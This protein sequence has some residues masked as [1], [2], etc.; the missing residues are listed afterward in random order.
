MNTPRTHIWP[1]VLA[2]CSQLL[3]AC[4]SE[5]GAPHVR[6][7]YDPI[8]YGTLVVGDAGGVE[9]ISARTAT[10]GSWRCSSVIL[11]SSWLLTAEHCVLDSPT[12]TTPQTV[13]VVYG[14]D[15]YNRSREADRVAVLSTQDI[16][17]VHFPDGVL[18]SLSN[19]MYGGSD[20]SLVGQT[21]RCYGYGWSDPVEYLGGDLRTAD[22]TV[23]ETGYYTCGLF[24]T[25]YC[26]PSHG[27]WLTRNSLGQI[28]A[29]GDSG[30]PCFIDYGATRYITGITH[31]ASSDG[32]GA[33]QVGAEDF[34]DWA[35]TT[36]GCSGPPG[37]QASCV[38][39]A[40]EWNCPTGTSYCSGQCMSTATATRT[41]PGIPFTAIKYLLE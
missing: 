11:N 20:Q 26:Y 19:G 37:S 32:T 16:A 15:S 23:T 1:L 4:G 17:L 27:Y 14:D 5:Q 40:C 22:L 13:I 2:A 30:G 24:S 10:H 39:G 38:N 28:M 33:S 9:E 21:L 3:L 35:C 36:I 41:C 12:Y 8:I 29:P 25:E 31:S 18:P 7:S 34:R 6:A